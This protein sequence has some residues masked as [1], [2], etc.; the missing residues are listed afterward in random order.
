MEELP[1]WKPFRNVDPSMTQTTLESAVHSM[2]AW[3]RDVQK[4]KEGLDYVKRSAGAWTEF[5]VRETLYDALV[6]AYVAYTLQKAGGEAAFNQENAYK[7][8]LSHQSGVRSRP[9]TEIRSQRNPGKS[10]KHRHES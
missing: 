5:Q 8:P 9:P 6:E 2:E 4:L 1:G 7:Y 3:L 10:D